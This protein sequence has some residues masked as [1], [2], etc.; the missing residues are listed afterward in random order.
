MTL[1]RGSW[2]D[3]MTSTGPNSSFAS[4]GAFP[5]GSNKSVGFSYYNVLITIYVY[6][7]P[8]RSRTKI[9]YG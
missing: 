2:M 5:P 9:F 7:N 4:V 1:A 6:T 8:I 3:V